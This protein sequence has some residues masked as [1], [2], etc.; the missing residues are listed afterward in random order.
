MDGEPAAQ[1]AAKAGASAKSSVVVAVSAATDGADPTSCML[2][3]SLSTARGQR[4]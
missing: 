2:A 1:P 3:D 4:P